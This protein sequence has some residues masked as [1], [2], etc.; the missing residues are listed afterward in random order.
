M[1]QVWDAQHEWAGFLSDLTSLMLQA[2]APLWTPGV[3]SRRLS[4]RHTRPSLTWQVRVFDKDVLT[5]DDSLGEV[6]VAL[7]GLNRRLRVDR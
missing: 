2:R 4:P 3:C 7:S 6:S 5:Y 1:A